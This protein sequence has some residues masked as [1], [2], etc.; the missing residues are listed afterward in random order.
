MT[1]DANALLEN[2]GNHLECVVDLAHNIVL[3]RGHMA[4]T[5]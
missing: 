2:Y 4:E 3:Y 1:S 5:D